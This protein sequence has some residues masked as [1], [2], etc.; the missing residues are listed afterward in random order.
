MAKKK[1]KKKEVSDDPELILSSIEQIGAYVTS[2]LDSLAAKYYINTGIWGLNYAISHGGIPS[3]Y[4]IECHGANGIG[5]SSLALHLSKQ[6]SN[7]GFNVFYVD[8]ERAINDSLAS[9][10]LDKSD[11]I[12]IHPDNGENALDITTLILK[13]TQK[14]FVVFDSVG[15]CTPSQIED[16]SAGDAHIGL[17]ARLMSNF[18]GPA[19]RYCKANNNVL[20]C[21]N[22]ETANITPMGARGYNISGG[23]KWSYVPDLRIRLTKKY[24]SG[25]ITEGDQKIGHIIHTEIT[26][27]RHGPPYRSAELPLI[28]GIGIDDTRELVENAISFGII[29][30]TSAWYSYGD[31]K[32]QGIGNMSQ[33]LKDNPDKRKQIVKEL[34]EIVND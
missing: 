8:V 22:H 32:Q 14:S 1:K 17:H 3:T 11:A 18:G 34:N 25:D 23:R 28:Y 6:A 16:G 7:I 30:R 20:F 19:A 9:I 31:E 4:V 5:K 21:L 33:Y 24:P 2:D 15:G 29:K 27:N 10:F 12:W 13:T 26:K